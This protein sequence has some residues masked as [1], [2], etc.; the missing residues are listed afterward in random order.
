MVWLGSQVVCMLDSSEEGPGFKLQPAA[1]N[2]LGQTVHIHR[3]SV[4]Q[5]VKF[6]AALLRVVRVTAGQAWWKVMAAYR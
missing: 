1:G 3:A 4:Y 2:S 5:T 6:I